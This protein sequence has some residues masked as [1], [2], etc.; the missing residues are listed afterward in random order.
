LN[1][2][3]S[4]DIIN[5]RCPSIRTLNFSREAEKDWRVANRMA[6][7]LPEL[8]VSFW[9]STSN[10]STAQ[11]PFNST[12]FDY[13]TAPSSPI[14]NTVTLSANLKRPWLAEN[15]STDICG[16]GWNCSYV[17]SFVGPGVN[18][19]EYPNAG[20]SN[21]V[22]P[23]FDRS[24]LVPQGNLSYLAATTLGEYSSTQLASAQVGGAPI[25]LP[26]FPEHLGAFRTEPVLWMGYA[27]LADD[28]MPLPRN[29]SDG[30]AWETAFKPT[31]QMCELFETN[32]TIQINYTL[33]SQ[34]ITIQNQTFLNRVVDT[35]FLPHQNSNDGTL[36][37]TTA[38]PESNYIY[39]I[40]VSRYRIT[41]AYHSISYLARQFI[42]GTI[43]FSQP[44]APIA[45]TDAL[46]SRLIDP[47]SYFVVPQFVTELQRFYV[48]I[49][50]SMFSNPSFIS[51][52]WAAD[53]SQS[54]GAAPGN[55]TSLL[56]PCTKT[57]DV[58]KYVYSSR[59]LWLVYGLSII[60]TGIGVCLG[61]AAIA[62]NNNH[63]RQI[64]FSSILGASRDESLGKLAWSSNKWGRV[65][66]E[67]LNVRLRYGRIDDGPQDYAAGE[68][69]DGQEA[70]YGFAPVEKVIPLG[71]LSGGR[72]SV[73]SFQ[74]LG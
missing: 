60:L 74:S 40:D 64:R 1:V 41:G 9:N 24:W 19:L 72:R 63:A 42:N 16:V 23:P 4:S 3:L 59:D 61:A 45:N 36:D 20:I 34:V 15:A 66:Q 13:W 62:Q 58:N 70:A 56:Y 11:V 14:V 39:P 6:D 67:V 54:S 48:D 43:D 18:C 21:Q 26:P 10:D 8:S 35:I 49:L 46:R 44:Q 73:L 22:V 30:A 47:G 33:S 38:V 53:P 55:G 12:F 28:Q 68:R 50:M 27:T 5:T 25:Q 69:G 65:P 7:N 2:A 52:V 37:N 32:Y 17:I 71:D 51:V 29:R 57:R 31:I